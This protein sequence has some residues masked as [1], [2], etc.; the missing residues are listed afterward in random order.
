MDKLNSRVFT[1][2]PALNVVVQ[3]EI[4]LMG[5]PVLPAVPQHLVP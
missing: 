4:L 5:Q 2:P 1:I 3:M